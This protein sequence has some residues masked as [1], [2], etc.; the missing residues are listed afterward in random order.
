MFRLARTYTDPGLSAN[1]QRGFPAPGDGAQLTGDQSQPTQKFTPKTAPKR[2]TKGVRSFLDIF[3]QRGFA[4]PQNPAEHYP[5]G[6]MNN[7]L[8]PDGLNHEILTPYFDRGAAAFVQNY[9][10]VT[11]NPIGAGVQVMDRPMASYGVSAEY[12]NGSIWWTPQNIPTS[13]PG[14]SLTNPEDLSAALGPI[15][16]QAAVR[17]AGG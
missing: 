14:Q 7:V 3:T 5:A 8:I 13:I 17:F 10:K 1:V 11:V 9:G 2:P 12:H 15:N 6:T 16:V 4:E